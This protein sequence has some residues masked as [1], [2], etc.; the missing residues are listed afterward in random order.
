[1]TEQAKPLTA[2]WAILLMAFV[3]RLAWADGTLTA[4]WPPGTSFIYGALFSLFGPASAPSL[5]CTWSLAWR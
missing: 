3:L 4:F 1:M 5:R 2:L